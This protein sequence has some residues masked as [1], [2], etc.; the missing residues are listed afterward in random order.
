MFPSVMNSEEILIIYFEPYNSGFE[1]S[2]MI[3]KID[4]I[5]NLSYVEPPDYKIRYNRESKKSTS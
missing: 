3:E 1:G 2:F 5:D 4:S